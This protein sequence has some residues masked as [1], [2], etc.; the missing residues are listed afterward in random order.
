MAIPSV[1]VTNF[2]YLCSFFLFFYWKSTNKIEFVLQKQEDIQL[3]QHNKG[4]SHPNDSAS[5]SS[6][7]G[8]SRKDVSNR[9]EGR[10]NGEQNMIP[11]LLMF[12]PFILKFILIALIIYFLFNSA[13]DSLNNS[14]G[15]FLN[16][17]AEKIIKSLQN[18][19]ITIIVKQDT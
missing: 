5:G 13:I 10:P 3:V 2:L 1:V 17:T 15:R 16:D 11:V 6:S 14:I 4:S 7:Q 12:I 9:E 19:N 8:E 18:A